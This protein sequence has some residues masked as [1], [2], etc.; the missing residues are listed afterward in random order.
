[1]SHAAGMLSTLQA[2]GSAPSSP[3][4]RGLAP[5]WS[6]HA[7]RTPPPA[8]AAKTSA[9]APSKSEARSDGRSCAQGLSAGASLP[10]SGPDDSAGAEPGSDSPGCGT[11]GPRPMRA[12]R[13]RSGGLPAMIRAHLCRDRARFVPK[14]PGSARGDQAMASTLTRQ[15]DRPEY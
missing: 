9:A 7:V 8:H 12:T 4:T 10:G 15:P 11:A 1:V 3:I 5:R 2:T 6:A 13:S 14:G